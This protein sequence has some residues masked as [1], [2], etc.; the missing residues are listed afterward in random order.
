MGRRV[1]IA[2]RK[3]T[4]TLLVILG[5][6]IVTQVYAETPATF[7]A[8]CKD[9]TSYTGTK[10]S[11]ACSG[12]KGVQTWAASNPTS[13]AEK[14]SEMKPAAP[15][16]KPVPAETA[17]KASAKNKVAAVG[18]GVG[19]VWLNTASNVYHCYGSAGYGTTK[20]GA[21]MTESE[22]KAKGGHAS[23]SKACS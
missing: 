22:A 7:S 1:D 4:L 13:T 2:M 23:H 21:Y 11:G 10:K 8:T 17:I 16:I 3:T 14:K 5:N 12:H 19:K 18:G 6:L 20:T 15:A 9:G